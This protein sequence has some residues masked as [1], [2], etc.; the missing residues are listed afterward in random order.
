MWLKLKQL[1]NKKIAFCINSMDKGGAE[2][3]VSI[4]TNH[5]TTTNDV[6]VICVTKNNV[7]YELQSNIKLFELSSH[8][9]KVNN[10]VLKKLF[11]IPKMILRFIKLK[12]IFNRRKFDVVL[13]FL[14]EASF[15]ALMCKKKNMK[16][17]VSV[18]ND[19][20]I[21]YSSKF[22]WYFM[23]KLYP[24]ADGFVFQTQEAKE[25][26][27]SIIHFNK[28]KF[29][30][31]LNPVDPIF[32][33]IPDVSIR[34]KEIVSVG[35]LTEQKNFDL[36]I[37]AFKIVCSDIVDYNLIIYGEGE[38]RDY[39]EQKISQLSLTSRVILAGVSD[40]IKNKIYD[41]SLFVMSSDYEG[42]PNALIE[43]MCLGLPVISTDCPCGGPRFL[44]EH[45]QNGI[46]VPVNDKEKLAL[47]I[48]QLL[49]DEKLSGKI[50]KNATKVKNLVHP[51]S[52][53][54]E[55]E[56]F[57]ARVTED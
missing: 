19:P 37:D 4:L 21:E 29:D 47:S 33:S 10:R 38:K 46:L 7:A 31:I 55:W 8:P 9:S 34:K 43:A 25:Y 39:L 13:S 17:I 24:K 1:K 45:G 28:I 32:L 48:K 12:H 51:D 23:N 40:N 35:R 36:L 5:L 49:M 15:L 52:V 18:R 26:F 22:Y 14:P 6:S 50:G 27:N 2:R 44:I 16:M 54:Q 53:N 30:I 20:K 56:D 57:I 3:V 42:M 11:L 41:S